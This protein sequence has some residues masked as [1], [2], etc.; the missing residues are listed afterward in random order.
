M[1]QTNM[2]HPVGGIVPTLRLRWGEVR[3]QD[4]QVMSVD[5]PFETELDYL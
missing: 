2:S 3:S 4:E 5:Q 1:L